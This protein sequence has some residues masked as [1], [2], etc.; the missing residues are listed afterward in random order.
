VRTKQERCLEAHSGEAPALAS[1]RQRRGRN[2]S[3]TGDNRRCQP[4]VA[5]SGWQ[6]QPSVAAALRR[7]AQTLGAGGRGGVRRGSRSGTKAALC[8]GRTRVTRGARWRASVY[9]LP[10][11]AHLLAAEAAGGAAAQR[12]SAVS[13]RCRPTRNLGNEPCAVPAL[14]V[15]TER[16]CSSKSP[17]RP[18]CPL[19][20]GGARPL[21]C[22]ARNEPWHATL[23]RLGLEFHSL[24]IVL[25]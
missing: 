3:A 1:D 2:P 12:R 5:T 9:S 16:R 7:I 19:R 18:A 20:P 8:V 21:T 11:F 6:Q 17:T 4:K 15:C 10:S 13:H 23:G 25:H 22:A 14:T 24:S